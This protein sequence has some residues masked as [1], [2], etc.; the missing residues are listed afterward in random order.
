M[1]TL[2]NSEIEIGMRIQ[3][4]LTITT[5]SMKAFGGIVHALPIKLKKTNYCY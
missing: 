5:Q 3:R 1:L 4:R 2:I